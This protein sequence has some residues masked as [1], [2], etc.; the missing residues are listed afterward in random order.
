MIVE[1]ILVISMINLKFNISIFC[2][3]F[4]SLFVCG[5]SANDVTKIVSKTK[6]KYTSYTTLKPSTQTSFV[7]LTVS[8]T[9]TSTS[10]STLPAWISTKTI[11][12][13]TQTITNTVKTSVKRTNTYTQSVSYHLR[14][15]ASTTITIPTE[16]SVVTKTLNLE[17]ETSTVRV[18]VSTVPITTAPSLLF[19]YNFVWFLTTF[20]MKK[21]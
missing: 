17:A 13:I 20:D 16:T 9:I 10:I 14:F 3:V 2:L 7:P 8:K 6:T 21:L 11:S 19:C 12:T 4:L 1:L 15:L 18:T 5:G